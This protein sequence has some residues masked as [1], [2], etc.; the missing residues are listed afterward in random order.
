KTIAEAVHFAHERGVHHR[1]LK[2]SNVLLDSQDVPH[3]TDFGLAKLLEPGADLTLTGQVLG[4]PSYMPPEQ[5]DPNRGET[6]AASDVYSLGAVLYH[7]LT[8]RPPFMAETLTQTLRLVAEGEAGSPRLLNPAVPRDLETVC[9]KCLD[10]DPKR[11][12]ATAQELAEELGRFL[13]DEPIRARPIASVVRL[14][15]WFRRKPA[16]AISLGAITILLV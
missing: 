6:T 9:I 8:S 14:A 1:D 10:K 16:L 11:R 7:L 5:A 12:Y 13:R 15:R 2:P 4:T 3:V